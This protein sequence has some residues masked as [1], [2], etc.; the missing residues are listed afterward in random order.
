MVATMLL[1]CH[2]HMF[3]P[4][5]LPPLAAQ[6]CV[7]TPGARRPKAAHSLALRGA[8]PLPGLSLQ[9]G[10]LRSLLLLLCARHCLM[11]LW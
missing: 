7:A 1:G 5:C 2:K 4:L 8:E 11:C 3:Q 10:V 9:G 6:A